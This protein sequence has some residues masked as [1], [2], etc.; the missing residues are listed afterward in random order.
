[1]TNSAN[2]VAASRFAE[3]LEMN[4]VPPPTLPVTASSPAQG[5]GAATPI[6][7]AGTAR[8][9]GLLKIA[10]ANH[11]GPGI[12]RTLPVYC[13]TNSGEKTL[14]SVSQPACTPRS[15][16]EAARSHS[17]D[18]VSTVMARGPVTSPAPHL[19][20]QRKISGVNASPAAPR[21]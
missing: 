11:A 16:M 14:L 10:P 21:T 8:D 7:P 17:G 1:V 20:G 4:Q 18:V 6:W 2:W 13:W 19:L 15:I 9:S 3:W 12:I 5:S